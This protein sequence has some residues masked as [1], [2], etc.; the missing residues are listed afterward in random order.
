QAAAALERYTLLYDFAPVGY[1][2]LKETGQVEEINLTGALMLGAPRSHI[3]GQPLASYFT[4]GAQLHDHLAETCKKGDNLITELQLNQ[5]DGDLLDVQLE[6]RVINDR[7]GLLCGVHTIMTNIA[8]RKTLERELQRQRGDMESL[9]QQQV[10][11]QTASAIAHDLNQPLAAVSVYSEVA[12]RYLNGE[13]VN[14]EQLRRA[15]TGCVDQS[16]RAGRSLHELLNF[17]HKGELTCEAMD[18]NALIQE[19]LAIARNDGLGGFQPVLN[20]EP[21]LPPVL[22]N[23]IQVKKVL[24]NLLRNSVEAMREANIPMAAII[25]KVTTIAEWN[26][27]QVTVQDSGPGLNDETIKNIFQPFF[28]TKPKGIG[29]GLAISRSLIEANGG[30]LW[31]EPDARPGAT[32]H[33]TLPFAPST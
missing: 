4:A 12:I 2:T 25:I 18:L 32:F 7:E 3:I 28:T 6:S 16:K 22:G 14:L 26:L 5:P 20:L 30:Q 1:L 27:A 17:L 33:F 15:L 31:V 21:E 10:A 19:A 9:L 13:S 24:V 23:R 11:A 29:L 8:I